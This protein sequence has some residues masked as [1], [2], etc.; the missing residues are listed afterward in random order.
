MGPLK[1]IGQK[2]IFFGS[3]HILFP[4][5]LFLQHSMNTMPLTGLPT[6]GQNRTTPP[7]EGQPPLITFLG[8]EDICHPW[9]V[10]L[11]LGILRILPP[12][13]GLGCLAVEGQS[14]SQ[15]E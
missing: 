1:L 3:C 13:L 7:S 11:W 12:N 4:E 6:L 9:E 10:D 14:S 2:K 15:G 8:P 5:P